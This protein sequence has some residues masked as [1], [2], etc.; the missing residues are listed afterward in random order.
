VSS[1]T[2]AEPIAGSIT[3][4]IAALGREHPSGLRAVEDAAGRLV[5]AIDLGD[6]RCVV[7]FGAGPPTVRGGESGS[8][9]VVVRTDRATTAAVL[10]G[11]LSLQA[12]VACA[13]LE[14]VGRI[15]AVTRAYDA[16]VTFVAATIHSPT[17]T[18]LLRHVTAGHGH[19]IEEGEP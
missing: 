3:R 17:Q 6:D 19:G 18:T 14:V 1:S 2:S 9:D 15:D 16:L 5:V 8:A 10:Q 11:R 7:G 12:A 13:R 4:S